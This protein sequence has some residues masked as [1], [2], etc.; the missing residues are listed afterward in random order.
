M[1]DAVGKNIRRPFPLMIVTGELRSRQIS[2]DLQTYSSD[3]QNTSTETITTEVTKQ[4]FD[5]L[6]A[7]LMR[8]EPR[9][10]EEIRKSRERMDLLR[11]EA[12]RRV[13]TVEVAVDF[14]RE[15]R[16]Q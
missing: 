8:G 9:D 6:I 3:N 1:L 2:V 13:G 15:H 12:R 10:P 5:E 4:E 14:M 7:K 11:E 16:D